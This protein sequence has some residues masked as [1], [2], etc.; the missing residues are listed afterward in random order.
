[1]CDVFEHTNY[2]GRNIRSFKN[3]LAYQYSPNDILAILYSLLT[4]TV[5][6]DIACN[7]FLSSTVI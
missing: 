1:M 7:Y 3:V 2:K 5:S 4:I 6:D